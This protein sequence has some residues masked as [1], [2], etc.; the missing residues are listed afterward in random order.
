MN[1]RIVLLYCLFV[2]AAPDALAWNRGH[3]LKVGVSRCAADLEAVSES[4]APD[5]PQRGRGMLLTPH[6][7]KQDL[8]NASPQAQV[9]AIS[10]CGEMYRVKTAD[11][12][13]TKISEFNLRFKTDSSDL[14][15]RSGTPVI[16]RAGMQGD[17]ASVV[18]A[19]PG[20]ISSFIN[21]ACPMKGDDAPF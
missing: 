7:G 12:K 4:N 21:E 5:L 15:P 16:V 13:I 9:T 19:A 1:S 6:A 2:V 10:H 20:E 14:G 17:R 3:A 11:G 18:F 8:K